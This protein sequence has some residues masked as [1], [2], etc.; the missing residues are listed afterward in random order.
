MRGRVL[1]GVLF[2]AMMLIAA[3]TIITTIKEQAECRDR[4]GI[5]VRSMFWYECI[6]AGR[7]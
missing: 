5:F 2:V 6:N 1:A 4:G 3:F 7:K